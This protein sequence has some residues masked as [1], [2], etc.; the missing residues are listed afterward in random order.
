MMGRGRG[1]GGSGTDGNG[2]GLAREPS[3]YS[4]TFDELQSTLGVAG[5]DFGSMNMDEL[6]RNIWSAEESQA[7]AAAAPAPAPAPAPAL[8]LDGA[9]AGLQRQGSLTLPR[10]LSQKTVDQVWRDLICPAQQGM[11]PAAGVSHQHRQP[12]LGEMTL[13]EFLVRAGAVRDELTPP[14]TRVGNSGNNSSSNNNNNA[15]SNVHFRDLPV[16][17]NVAHLALGFPLAGGSDRDVV[18]S[19]PFT[20]TTA[21]NLAM[22]VTTGP[23]PYVAPMAPREGV[24]GM[25]NP[26]GGGLVGIG[27]VG[28]NNRLMPGAVGLGAAGGA[29]A[30]GTSANHLPS[31]APRKHGADLSS[32]SPVPYVVTGGPRGKKSSAVDN[33]LERRQRRMIKN[34]E[35]AARSRDRKQAYTMK[36][37]AEVAE[38]QELNQ[39]LNKKQGE[40]ME[41]QKDQM[42]EMI[43]QQQGPKKPC[44]RR[45]QTVSW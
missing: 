45:T 38:L 26:R 1:G 5:N 25:G 21:T 40:L 23:S 28:I 31:D 6:L 33:V 29:A 16:A 42:L 39:E 24:V 43:N 9:F 11:P 18:A 27:D 19:N 8:A 4:L 22:M 30:V 15:T 32:E 36:L 14:Q 7:M 13:E 2:G 44:L 10:T 12:T 20:D 17:N 34:R 3:I 37:E 41:M 35:S